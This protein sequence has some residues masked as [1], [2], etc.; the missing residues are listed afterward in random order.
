MT[1]IS[2]L[3][4]QIGAKLGAGKQGHEAK[5]GAGAKPGFAP[6]LEAAGQGAGEGDKAGLTFPTVLAPT[7][8]EPDTGAGP[9][10]TILATLGASAKDA[11]A[12][13][14][15]SAV[16]DRILAR[17]AARV[18][19]TEAPGDPGES[20]TP[21]LKTDGKTPKADK[22]DKAEKS[23][24]TAIATNAALDDVAPD[25]APVLTASDAAPAAAD[26][27]PKREKADQASAG[28]AT[29]PVPLAQGT[30]LP[31]AALLAQVATLAPARPE[32]ATPRA[33]AAAPVIAT[34]AAPPQ[35]AGRRPAGE[36]AA[37][38]IAAPAPAQGEPA[39]AAR[40]AEAPVAATTVPAADAA[41][42]APTIAPGFTDT[43]ATPRRA[44][45]PPQRRVAPAVQI[46]DAATGLAAIAGDR[47]LPPPAAATGTGAGGP[48]LSATLGDKVI[49]MGVGGQWIDRMARE[50]VQVASGDG[51]ASF[52]L[53]PPALGRLQVEMM[54][55]AAGAHVHLT[56][57]SDDAVGRLREARPTLEAD[58]RI[59]AL[60]L[61]SVVIDK[62][63]PSAGGNDAGRQGQSQPGW[64]GAGAGRQDGAA[65]QGQAFA[66]QGNGQG[67]GG[68]SGKAP[69]AAAVLNPLDDAQ[70]ARS[71]DPSALRRVRYA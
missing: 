53:H 12:A 32:Q 40:Q 57:E 6:L 29:T 59:A 27:K 65:A 5:G 44:D 41:P 54:R 58:A 23:A 24:K 61:A 37:E 67:G 70:A 33:E 66:G 28:D 17:I 48:T 60:S 7:P 3:L 64:T 39:R 56:A 55:D 47:S 13:E 8:D 63:P 9:E 69:S 51:R 52:Q 45:A 35:R 2:E 1:V 4:T 42:A 38:M 68:Q 30:E 34:V 19:G 43:S 20:A 11:D 22:A 46:S 18:A 10:A 62:A 21:A 36:G 14:T 15:D 31:A 25:A 26:A 49:D 50:I 16:V 71:T